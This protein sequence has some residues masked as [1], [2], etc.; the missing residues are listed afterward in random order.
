M[1]AEA[2]YCQALGMDSGAA[3]TGRAG[4]RLLIVFHSRSG[5]TE[6]LV[7]NAIRGAL[8]GLDFD[9]T[10]GHEVHGD[11]I[12]VKRAFDA[13]ENDVLGASGIL[14]ATPA[15]FGYMSGA[16]KDFFERVYNPCLDK[17]ARMPYALIVKGSTDVEGAASS[18]R[19]IVKGMDWREVLPALLVVGDATAQQAAEAEELGATFAAGVDAGIY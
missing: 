8:L 4:K 14:V 19:R 3:G 1:F 13:D 2:A 17:T 18:V 11:R 7:Q 5:G 16:L 6:H 9:P 15:N 12:C 10:D